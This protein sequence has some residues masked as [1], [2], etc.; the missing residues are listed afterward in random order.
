MD[1]EICRAC[2]RYRVEEICVQDLN[3]SDYLE[4]GGVDG[5]NIKMGLK[6]NRR[7]WSGLIWLR[8]GTSGSYYGH[9]KE[10]HFT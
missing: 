9:G 4:D 5:D 1:N 6:V 2:D 3:E 7:L 8:I 10:N